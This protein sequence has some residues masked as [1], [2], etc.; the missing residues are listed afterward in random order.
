MKAVGIVLYWYSCSHA[1]T[2][3]ANL[4]CQLQETSKS[5]HDIT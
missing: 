4:I 3:L 5:E 1:G 2:V